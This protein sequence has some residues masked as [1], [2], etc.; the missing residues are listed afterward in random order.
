MGRPAIIGNHFMF[1][2]NGLLVDAVTVGKDTKPDNDPTTNWTDHELGCVESASMTNDV[3]EESVR[4]P[5]AG[6]GAYQEAES[7]ALQQNLSINMNLKELNPLVWQIIWMSGA[8]TDGGGGT[9]AFVPL[10]AGAFLKGWAR[11]DQYDESNVLVNT[12]D[13]YCQIRLNG[14]VDF[15]EAVT[16]VPITCK[17]FTNALN[18]GVLSSFF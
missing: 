6:G 12:A 10:S 5:V 14:N 15:Q 3:Q 7:F 1:L 17:V 4:C 2:R 11:L 9:G 8:I 13:F 16:T 18:T